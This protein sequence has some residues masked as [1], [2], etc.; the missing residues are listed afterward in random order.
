MGSPRLVLAWAACHRTGAPQ[1]RKASGLP[2]LLSLIQHPS[3][4][5]KTYWTAR[6]RSSEQHLQDEV[7]AHRALI[8]AAARL[9]AGG[10]FDGWRGVNG[11]PPVSPPPAS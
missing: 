7:A 8:N 3:D 5:L 4:D 2:R 9:I 6:A 10:G 1:R 11:W